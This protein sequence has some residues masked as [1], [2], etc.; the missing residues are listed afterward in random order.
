MVSG[1]AFRGS[2]LG[3]AVE[4]E[5]DE[6]GRVVSVRLDPRTTRRLRPD[7]LGPGVVAAHAQARAAVA[8]G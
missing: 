5:V 7:Q 8:R 6:R 1:N 4:V 3:G 2:A